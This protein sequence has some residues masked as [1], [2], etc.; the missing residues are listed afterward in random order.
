MLI[1]MLALLPLAITGKLA[2]RDA[3]AQNLTGGTSAASA[4]SNVRGTRHNLSSGAPTRQSTS[5]NTSTTEAVVTAAGANSTSEVCVFC[6]TPHGATSPGT[7]LWNRTLSG[8]TYTPYSSSSL[9]ATDIDVTAAAMAAPSKLCMS[10][11]DGTIALGNVANAP[12][13]SSGSA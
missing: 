1:A 11:H 3:I 12:G 8:A 10:C 13:S 4:P 2:G 6:H 5:G 9:Q 7:P